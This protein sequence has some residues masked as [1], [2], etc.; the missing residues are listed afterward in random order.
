MSGGSGTELW[1]GEDCT[2]SLIGSIGFITN[3]VPDQYSKG[4][5]A[6]IELSK[7]VI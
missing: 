7:A 4:F 6:N 5:N 3:I 1:G 2:K